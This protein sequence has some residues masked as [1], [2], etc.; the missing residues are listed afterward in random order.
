MKVEHITTKRKIIKYSRN[1]K[2]SNC[3]KKSN[4][5]ENICRNNFQLFVYT[6]YRVQTVIS[7]NKME[8]KNKIAL[9]TI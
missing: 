9:K 8:I 3:T 5:N 1:K 2:L 4:R 6:Y 7:L